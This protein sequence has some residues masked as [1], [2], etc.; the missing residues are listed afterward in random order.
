MEATPVRVETEED[1]VD[2]SRTHEELLQGN[3]SNFIPTLIFFFFFF[4]FFELPNRY[5]TSAK[6]WDYDARIGLL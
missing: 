3:P 4:L 2:E 6:L 1:E 5:E